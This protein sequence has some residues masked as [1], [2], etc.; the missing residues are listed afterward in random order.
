MSNTDLS[1][2]YVF[3]VG[4]AGGTAGGTTTTT[5][6]IR[7]APTIGARLSSVNGTSV[8]GMNFADTVALLEESQTLQRTLGF[9]VFNSIPTT[10]STTPTTPTTLTPPTPPTPTTKENNVGADI[11]KLPNINRPSSTNGVRI[12]RTTE[13]QPRPIS[14]GT[15]QIENPEEDDLLQAT[16]HSRKQGAWKT[17]DNTTTSTQATQIVVPTSTLSHHSKSKHTKT[18][19]TGKT[20]KHKH[21]VAKQ[22]KSDPYRGPIQQVLEQ[23]LQKSFAAVHVKAVN[24]TYYYRNRQKLGSKNFHERQTRQN[25]VRLLC[26]IC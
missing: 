14:A 16:A 22:Q 12:E 15:N 2:L 21:A 7:R 26:S 9:D 19:K 8:L 25:P 13:E 5:Q 24:M 20:G 6:P 11:L 4:T 23:A 18:G 1:L 3:I 17:D 10:T